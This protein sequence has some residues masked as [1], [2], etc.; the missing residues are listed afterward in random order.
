MGE[1]LMDLNSLKPNNQ[2]L[3]ANRYQLQQ[4]LGQHQGRKTYLAQDQ[5]TQAPVVVK[6]LIFNEDFEWVD[7]KLFEREANVLK[8]LAH[9]A[10]PRYLDYFDFDTPDLGKGVALVQTYIPAQSLA[11]HVQSVR[12]FTEAEIKHIAMAVLEI[13]IYLQ[14]RSPAVIHRDIKPS[15]ILLGDSTANH[16]GQVYL[17]DFGSVQAPQKGKT[18]TLVGTYGFMPPEQFGGRALPNSDL[19]SLGMTLIYLL[20]GINPTDL[21]LRGLNVKFEH[22]V[23][24][25]V[26]LELIH[27]LRQM[28]DADPERRL[29]SAA[30]ALKGL[31]N[32]DSI[33]IKPRQSQIQLSRDAD[34]FTMLTPP[35]FKDPQ[36][37]TYFLKVLLFGSPALAMG[38]VLAPRLFRGIMNSHGRDFLAPVLGSIAIVLLIIFIPSFLRFLKSFLM[39]WLGRTRLYLAPHGITYTFEMLGFRWSKAPVE[40]LSQISAVEY[41][42]STSPIM[43]SQAGKTQYV[44]YKTSN[45][46]F[47]IL[48]AG[49]T[50]YVLKQEDGLLITEQELKWLAQE[51]KQWLDIW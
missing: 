25:Q 10:I 23:G 32:P 41:K 38:I 50:Q 3:L 35:G 34:S 40:P 37:Q 42:S 48:Q 11:Q 26:S 6:C 15:N 14:R 29:P 30:Q 51:L 49:K 9:P 8:D 4:L 31:Q 19:Y 47:L 46:P 12:I 22:L 36:L 44:E 18:F 7:L 2:E 17:I 13:L 21:P 1:I 39:N 33:A 5:N 24:G 27:W 45:F 28:I 43:I 20:T 16:P